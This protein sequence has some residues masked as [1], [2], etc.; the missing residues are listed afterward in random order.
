MTDY[1]ECKCQEFEKYSKGQESYIVLEVEEDAFQDDMMQTALVD[2]FENSLYRID[3]FNEELAECSDLLEGYSLKFKTVVQLDKNRWYL[4][5]Y[6][7]ELLFITNEGEIEQ[8][9]IVSENRNSSEADDSY[10]AVYEGYGKYLA[11]APGGVTPVKIEINVPIE[12]PFIGM[13]GWYVL[14]SKL[15]LIGPKNYIQIMDDAYYREE[16]IEEEEEVVDFF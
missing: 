13:H 10:M 12:A 3:D 1:V 7:E 6:F 14:N 2:T 15:E 5:R 8:Y 16:Q 4:T 11:Y 9:N